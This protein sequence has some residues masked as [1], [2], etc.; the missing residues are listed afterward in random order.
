MVLEIEIKKK[1]NLFG[2][3]ERTSK[4]KYIIFDLE[5]TCGPKYERIRNEIIE[6]GAVK[7]DN[8]LN[9]ISTFNEF[10]KPIL[11]PTL[12]EFC[13]NLTSISQEDIDKADIFPEVYKRFRS[14][15]EDDYLLLSWG[16]YDKKQF[17][18]DCELH[19]IESEW[20]LKHIN[21][22]GLYANRKNIK[23]M[24]MERALNREGILPEGIHHRGIDDAIN[25][26]KIFLKD[27]KLWKI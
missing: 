6:I 24:G 20:T 9:I 2:T 1:Q 5:A 18:S 26:S 21:F 19:G 22:K 12:T 8:N 14:W 7:I 23:Q 27:F 15:I 10:I 17:V 4:M 13:I 3:L 11:N 16:N 25:I